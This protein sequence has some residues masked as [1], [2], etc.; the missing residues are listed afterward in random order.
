[1]DNCFFSI[2]IPTFNRAERLKEILLELKKIKSADVEI[3]IVDNCSEDETK[4]VLQSCSDKRVTAVYNKE[5][6]PAFKN[7]LNSI[8]LSSGKYTLYCNDKDM[9]YAEK[10][11]ELIDY[12]RDKEFAALYTVQKNR[13]YENSGTVK[14]YEKGLEALIHI[15]YA[16]HPTG[17]VYNRY[18]MREYI[19][20][21]KEEF[22]GGYDGIYSWSLLAVD[23]T[24][25]GKFGIY[26]FGVWQ[27]PSRK[28]IKTHIAGT[29]LKDMWFNPLY[30]YRVAKRTASHIRDYFDNLS[31][32]ELKQIERRVFDTMVLKMMLNYKSACMSKSEMSHYGKRIK[33]ITTPHLVFIYLKVIVEIR[34]FE[35]DLGMRLYTTKELFIDIL[36]CIKGSLIY[37]ALFVKSLFTDFDSYGSD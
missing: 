23:L 8:F 10:I 2:V 14:V 4:S 36:R 28:F 27:L 3:L 1:M 7:I 31:S 16:D 29:G 35:K 5:P 12:L 34:S 33:L 24:K 19:D 17:M 9:L 22:Y 25:Y 37:D 18:L 30:R 20:S 11:D 15:S 6:V 32:Y 13:G 21:H 26:D